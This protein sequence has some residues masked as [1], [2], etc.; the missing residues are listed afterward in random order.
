MTEKN[1]S[2]ETIWTGATIRKVEVTWYWCEQTLQRENRVI[3]LLGNTVIFVTPNCLILFKLDTLLLSRSNLKSYTVSITLRTCPSL[4][5]DPLGSVLHSA[6]CS[7]TSSIPLYIWLQLGN[8][9]GA[10]LPYILV[11][12]TP[13]L[14][15]EPLE[16]HCI[17]IQ[18]RHTA[19]GE[20]LK[21]LL[22]IHTMYP[23]YSFCC[24][25]SLPGCWPRLWK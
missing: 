12:S 10:P 25:V 6:L 21:P 1:I 13:K 16:D 14:P 20:S 4:C 23:S 17:H 7:S 19:F 15:H 5:V 11:K 24:C 8:Q 2:A 18:R 3:I 22:C 9:W